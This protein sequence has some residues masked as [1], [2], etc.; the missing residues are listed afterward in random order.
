MTRPT[1]LLLGVGD[2]DKHSDFTPLFEA[3]GGRIK[4]VLVYGCNIP[5]VQEAAR[6]TGYANVTVSDG[7]FEQMVR[8]AQAIAEPGDAVLLS[9]AAA[10]W[11]RFSDYEQRGRIFKD[12]VRAL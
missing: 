11:G 6:R 7:S 4:H 2:Y 8:D 3:F 1:I 9:P 12:I 5:A 10:S